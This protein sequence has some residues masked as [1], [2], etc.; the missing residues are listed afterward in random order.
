MSEVH[1]RTNGGYARVFAMK[2][3]VLLVPN[4]A[5]E[6]FDPNHARSLAFVLLQASAECES[7]IDSTYQIRQAKLDASHAG[8]SLNEFGEALARLMDAVRQD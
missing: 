3:R 1:D 7:D 8:G 2:G 6:S 5:Q 4:D